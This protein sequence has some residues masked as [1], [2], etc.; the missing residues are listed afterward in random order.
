MKLS[1]NKLLLAM[2]RAQIS[3]YELCEKSRIAKPT[4][5]QLKAGRNNPK[6]VTIGKLAHALGVDPEDIIEQEVQQSW[7]P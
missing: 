1:V 4:L 6:P 7:N 3:D 5:A 2:A